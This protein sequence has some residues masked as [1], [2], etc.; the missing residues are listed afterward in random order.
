MK[1]IL[2]EK[3]F[4][5][6][7]QKAIAQKRHAPYLRGVLENYRQYRDFF[8]RQFTGED[9][10]DVF[11][12]RAKYR[13]KTPVWRDIQILGIQTLNILAETIVESMEWVNVHLHGF[14][15]PDE[16][17]MRI[18]NSFG[19]FHDGMED[20]PYPT[21]KTKHVRICDLPWK[22]EPIIGFMF[23]FG[24]GHEFDIQFRGRRKRTKKDRANA[25]PYLSDQRGVAPEQYPKELNY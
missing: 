15:L 6:I 21:Y 17:R 16:H 13:G 1:P 12:V 11:S 14:W 9:S 10:D 19:I 8:E 7:V 2:E 5:P 23:D 18:F 24:D 25:F 3:D 4:L 20:D 22:E